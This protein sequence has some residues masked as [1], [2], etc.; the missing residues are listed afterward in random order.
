M[1]DEGTNEMKITVKGANDRAAKS[2]M[3]G[4]DYVY[5]SPK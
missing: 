1:L 4:L 5:L 3:F 2:F